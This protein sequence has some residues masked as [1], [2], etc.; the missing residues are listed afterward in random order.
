MRKVAVLM[1]ALL[2]LTLPAEAMELTKQQAERF[3]VGALES[4]LPEAAEDYLS[5]SVLEERDFAEGAAEIISGTLSESGGY[6]RASAAMMMQLLLI[7]LLC[8]FAETGEHPLS[9]RAAAM[10]GVLAL[11][12]C[13]A[14]DLRTMIGLGKGTMDELM[15]FSTLLLPVM[16]SAAAASGSVTGAGALYSVAVLCSKVLV[17]FC[18][19]IMFPVLYAYLALGVADSALQETRLSKLRE[20]LSWLVKWGLKAV[21]YVF[22]GFLA[23]TGLLSGHVDATALKAA[24]VTLSGVVPVVGG[25]VSDAAEAVLYSAGLLKGAAGTFGMLAF[26]AVFASP[27]L[28]VGLHYLS[29]KLTAALGGIMGSS[30]CGFMDC[31]TNVMGFLLAMLGSCVVMCLISCCCFMRMVGL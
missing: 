29:F 25:I 4:G 24:K 20:L 11:T 28:Q 19:K 23:V 9:G 13:C 30:L 14:G 22:T 12:V 31:I 26:L 2:L 8:R 5:G 27:F 3:G 15:N 18:G 17:G 10:A 1:V 21:M 6:F 16:A 7:I